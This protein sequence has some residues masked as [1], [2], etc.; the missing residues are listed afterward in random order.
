MKIYKSLIFNLFIYLQGKITLIANFL[1][2]GI[3]IPTYP[4]PCLVGRV[5]A[6]RNIFKSG[7]VFR[8]AG[9]S[10]NLMMTTCILNEFQ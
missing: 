7:L 3:S 9:C 8:M 4:H 10:C 2:K 1:K 6:N 5:W